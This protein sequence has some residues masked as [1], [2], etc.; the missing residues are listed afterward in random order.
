MRVFAVCGTEAEVGGRG[1]PGKR[2]AAAVS[3]N[4][5]ARGTV[6]RGI[7]AGSGRDIRDFGETE[8]F[9]PSRV[10][11]EPCT[12]GEIELNRGEG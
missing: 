5:T 11:S 2:D 7:L 10:S 4:L 1:E 3:P 6:E 8:L 9:A 12:K